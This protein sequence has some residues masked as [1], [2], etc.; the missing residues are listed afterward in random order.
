M[1]I[2]KLGKRNPNFKTTPLVP[3]VEFARM[4]LVVESQV[5]ALDM[6]AKLNSVI[7]VY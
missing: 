2:R 6:G 7:M 5:E 4:V 1:L 3:E